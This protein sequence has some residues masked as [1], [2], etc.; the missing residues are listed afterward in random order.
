[1]L[2]NIISRMSRCIFHLSS[3]HPH[4]PLRS[5]HA[6]TQIASSR[7]GDAPCHILSSALYPQ[8][9]LRSAHADTEIASSRRGDD[10]CHILSSALY[11]QVPL[12]SAH[13]VTEIASS[14][15]GDAPCRIV[16][17][18]RT[19]LSAS[20]TAFGACGYPDSVFQTRRCLIPHFA[21]II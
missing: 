15:R 11:P 12:R 10:P 17:S 3:S 14:R 4:V 5:V 18:A 7:R 2:G 6:V 19:T 1:M 8:V 21:F 16:S 20:T 9:P 13:A